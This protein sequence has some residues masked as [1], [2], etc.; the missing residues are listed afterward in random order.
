ME[1]RPLLDAG[2][3]SDI[4]KLTDEVQV[5]KREKIILFFMT[6]FTGLGSGTGV[7]LGTF[8]IIAGAGFAATVGTAA[9]FWILV[10]GVASAFVAIPI[11]YM[12][13]K[14][15]F[16]TNRKLIN[17]IVEL[18]SRQSKS[19]DLVE[20]N[21]QTFFLTYLRLHLLYQDVVRQN[22]LTR[23]EEFEL[24]KKMENYAFAE[25]LPALRVIAEVLEQTNATTATTLRKSLAP[26]YSAA[27][28]FKAKFERDILPVLRHDYLD[29]ILTSKPR[30]PGLGGPIKSAVV[31][32]LG[33]FSTV[34]GT[35]WGVASM[36]LGAV[37]AVTTPASLLAFALL[38]VGLLIGVAVGAGVGYYKY[39]KAQ[40]E[41]L[42]SHLLDVNRQLDLFANEIDLKQEAMN[43]DYRALKKHLQET[44]VLRSVMSKDQI[45][46]RKSQ[47]VKRGL[48]KM[49]VSSSSVLFKQVDENEINIREASASLRPPSRH[50]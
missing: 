42:K 17:D 14:D 13:L 49:S 22:R 12:A 15:H 7:G 32:C 46:L 5:N 38:G 47:E 20:K 19:K 4:A 1:L 35:A 6:L 25:N 11:M 26:S 18:V 23:D 36:I 31:T 29:R 9:L 34:S 48:P 43:E 27:A 16:K 41:K 3:Q 50:L 24:K 8:S 10:A 40:R 45:E 44:Q 30:R 28:E 39:R 2:K 21:M 37:V 33:V